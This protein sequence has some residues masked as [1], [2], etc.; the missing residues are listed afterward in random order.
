MIESKKER[1]KVKGKNCGWGEIEEKE[2]EIIIMKG[3]KNIQ[4]SPATIVSCHFRL[5][6]SACCLKTN[7]SSDTSCACLPPCMSQIAIPS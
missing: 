4:V 2:T 7:S 6:V 3:R 5:G 1:A